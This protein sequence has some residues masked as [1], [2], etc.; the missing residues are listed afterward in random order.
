[1]PSIMFTAEAEA[2]REYTPLAEGNYNFEILDTKFGESAKGT[3][4]MELTLREVDSNRRVWQRLY[5][6][7]TSFW[8][9]KG[10][11][12]AVG[13]PAEAGVAYD[14]NPEFA[15]AE[16]HGKQVGGVVSIEE[17]NEK[18]SNRVD[19]FVKPAERPF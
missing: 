6:A 4:F 13:H 5:F 7:P 17:Y 19:R 16:L 9:L 12:E 18:K 3:E 15:A 14:I 11:L 1:M 2:K 10:L 8:K